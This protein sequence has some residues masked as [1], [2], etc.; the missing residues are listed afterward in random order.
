MNK[1]FKPGLQKIGCLAVAMLAL[2]LNGVGCAVCCS[3]G[4]IDACCTSDQRT[5]SNSSSGASDCCK[6]AE[7]QSSSVSGGSISRSPE[8]GCS[9]LP[10][11]IPSLLRQASAPN[12]FAAVL[13]T[14]QFLPKPGL[15]P[16][17]RGY[18][19]LVLPA[20][21]GSTYLSCCVLLI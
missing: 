14:Y 4:L 6:E 20:N 19:R 8:A 15:D 1:L 21:R 5:C 3:A 11:Q 17:T 9:L 13:P 16:D 7:K 12:L 18:T 10:K 2:W